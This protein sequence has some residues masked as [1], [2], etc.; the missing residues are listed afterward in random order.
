MKQRG[1]FSFL[2]GSAV[3]GVTGVKMAAA[4]PFAALPDGAIVACS[5]DARAVMADKIAISSVAAE[6]IAI[7]SITPGKLAPGTISALRID[8]VD[9]RDA[10]IGHLRVTVS[11]IANGCV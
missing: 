9:I 6:K 11:D 8:H 5:I 7:G 4:A 1:F 2:V 3:A 10:V